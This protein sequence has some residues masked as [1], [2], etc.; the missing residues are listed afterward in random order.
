VGGYVHK[1]EFA[2]AFSQRHVSGVLDET[3]I[4]VVYR[5]SHPNLVTG[6]TFSGSFSGRVAGE[7]KDKYKANDTFAHFHGLFS[8]RFPGSN[9]FLIKTG[10]IK[11]SQP[12]GALFQVLAGAD[13]PVRVRPFQ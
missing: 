5:D 8:F 6:Q 4:I 13:I 7:G 1:S 3:Q 9:I 11:S 12:A 2:P 10:D